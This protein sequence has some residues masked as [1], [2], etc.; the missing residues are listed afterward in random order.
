ME[1]DPEMPMKLR[2]PGWTRLPRGA[3]WRPEE[4]AATVLADSAEVHTDHTP[5]GHSRGS[6]WPP[7][8]SCFRP[9]QMERQKLLLS[10]VKA[11]KIVPATRGV[12]ETDGQVLAWHR[13]S[14]IN[15]R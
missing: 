8:A 4:E 13:G 6:M 1:P 11:E 3:A 15:R 2:S 14:G 9:H 5:T 7:V 12:V 10:T